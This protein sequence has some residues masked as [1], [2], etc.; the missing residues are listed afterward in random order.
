M[1]KGM[2]RF[3]Q[4]LRIGILCAGFIICAILQ[5]LQAVGYF[6][7][8]KAN[9]APV[10]ILAL[11][12]AILLDIC[13]WLVCSGIHRLLVNKLYPEQTHAQRLAKHTAIENGYIDEVEKVVLVP[14]NSELGQKILTED[15]DTQRHDTTG[16]KN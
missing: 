15:F 2:Y 13:I 3:F 7:V 12:T 10:G 11:L 8:P 4:G 14:E 9:V 16:D 6:I 1:S 5:V